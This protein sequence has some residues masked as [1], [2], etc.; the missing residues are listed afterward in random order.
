MKDQIL[1]KRLAAMM[2]MGVVGATSLVG[3]SGDGGLGKAPEASATGT[4]TT[5]P[6][7][8]DTSTDAPSASGNV[9][10]RPLSIFES[11]K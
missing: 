10:F 3:C 11:S 5:T 1:L 2:L 8:T 9:T 6:T 7:E 4:E